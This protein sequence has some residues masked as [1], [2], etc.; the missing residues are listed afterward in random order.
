MAPQQIT[1]GTAANQGLI[2]KGAVSQTGDLIQWQNSAG[3]VLTAVTAAGIVLQQQPT[4]T[5]VN[6]TATLTVAQLLTEIITATSAT[7]VSMTLPTGTLMDGGFATIA[8]G[9]AFD[10]SIINLGSSAGAVTLLAGTSHTIVGSAT[11]AITTSARF[12]S[13]R[14]GATTWITYRLS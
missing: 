10:W 2:I 8:T 6:A 12:R 5:A 11:V 3:T 9:E 13:L 1:I 14:S 7:A 4:P